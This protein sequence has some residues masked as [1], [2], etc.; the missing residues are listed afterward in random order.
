LDPNL[1]SS[2]KWHAQDQ[3]SRWL[4]D[5]DDFR[6]IESAAIDRAV[7]ADGLPAGLIS[8]A[9]VSAAT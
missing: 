7:N 6:A 9:A 5:L 8:A 1:N 4:V 2:Y 3:H